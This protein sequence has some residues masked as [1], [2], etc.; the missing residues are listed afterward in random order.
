MIIKNVDIIVG[1][2][3]FMIVEKVLYVWSA[4]ARRQE[5]EEKIQSQ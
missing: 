3:V 1:W 5:R 2:F 4:S